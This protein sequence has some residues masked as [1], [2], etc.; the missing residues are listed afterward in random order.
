MIGKQGIVQDFVRVDGTK[1]LAGPWS[2]GD[3]IL[4]NAIEAYR[5]F[6]REF[7]AARFVEWNA[8]TE[9]VT[10]SGASAVTN[11]GAAVHTG[12]THASTA[13]RYW[14]LRLPGTAD[15]NSINWDKKWM[16]AFM[17]RWGGALATNLTMRL[18]LTQATTIGDLAAHG[19]GLQ[20]NGANINLVTYGTGGS[21]ATVSASTNL[22][23]N[24]R[25]HILIEHDP[26]S[27]DRLYIGG[28]L[29]AT[30]STAA[31]IPS[32]EPAAGYVIFCSIARSGGADTGDE[33]FAVENVEMIAE[34]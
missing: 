20:T 15:L 8:A 17:T 13:G 7:W 27:A 16:L 22:V 21:M 5:A 14:Y 18:H 28:V 29:K 32:T 25:V 33:Y 3:Q 26:A 30:Q 19:L 9:V 10:G 12:A 34:H 24:D 31:N 1:A 2:L 23:S 4:S 11:D 6:R